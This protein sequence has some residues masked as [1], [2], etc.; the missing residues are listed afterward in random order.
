MAIDS[1]REQIL[2]HL[3]ALVEGLSSIKTVTRTKQSYAG[4]EEFAITQLPLVAVV[5]RLPQPVEHI[6]RRVP[7]G[8]DLIVSALPVEFYVYSTDNENPDTLI[9]NLADDLWA[10][11][12][13]D[14]T[15]GGL[16]ISVL[17]KFSEDPQSWPPYIAFR[18]TATIKY[19]HTIGGI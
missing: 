14:Q 4:L 19:K 13:A 6:N 8:V 7:G 2:V 18:I 15:L 9:S 1:I 16:A 12:Y 3:K 11:L 5:G 17:L 10:L